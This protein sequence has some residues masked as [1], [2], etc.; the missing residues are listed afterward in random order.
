MNLTPVGRRVEHLGDLDDPRVDRSKRYDQ[1]GIVAIAICGA[2]GGAE[3][4]ADREGAGVSN[5]AAL[6][7]S[8]TVP[9]WTSR[10]KGLCRNADCVG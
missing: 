2:V 8:T 9:G 1:P 7:T 10:S 5:V 3:S 4:W 6:Y